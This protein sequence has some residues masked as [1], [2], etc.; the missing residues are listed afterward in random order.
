[1]KSKTTD[2][3]TAPRL[4]WDYTSFMLVQLYLA[5]IHKEQT[6]INKETNHQTKLQSIYNTPCGPHSTDLYVS[7]SS[8][9]GEVLVLL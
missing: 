8:H 1:M 9:L 4:A 5:V 3:D 7:A 6:N 2:I